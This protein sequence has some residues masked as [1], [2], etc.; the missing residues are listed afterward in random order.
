MLRMA[1]T[2]HTTVTALP[3]MLFVKYSIAL[4]DGMST[5]SKSKTNNGA[6]KN[7][8]RRRGLQT[9]QT[10]TRREWTSDRRESEIPACAAEEGDQ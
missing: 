6:S 2:K 1:G 10:R 5:H 9:G 3:T 7:A 8:N 4:T